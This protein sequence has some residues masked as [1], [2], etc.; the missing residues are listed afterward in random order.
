MR[1]IRTIRSANGSP[2]MD[3]SPRDR[4]SHSEKLTTPFMIV[5]LKIIHEIYGSSKNELQAFEVLIAEKLGSPGPMGVLLEL[6]TCC[7]ENEWEVGGHPLEHP[8]RIQ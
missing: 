2:P 6:S 4:F 5:A 3:P 1:Y 7:R 8:G